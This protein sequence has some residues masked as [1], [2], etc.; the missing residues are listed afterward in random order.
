MP[1]RINM[2]KKGLCE[3][4]T[5]AVFIHHSHCFPVV[6]EDQVQDC[7]ADSCIIWVEVDIKQVSVVHR[8]VFP[9]SL[10]VWNF[11]SIANG[12]HSAHRRAVGR[13][14]EGGYTKSQLVAS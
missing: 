10:N 8:G 11:Q 5:C 12:L 14:K 4:H 13:A 1:L 2:A 7:P 3:S 9:A 6:I